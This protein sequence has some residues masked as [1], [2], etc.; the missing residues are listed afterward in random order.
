MI[1]SISILPCLSITRV[2]SKSTSDQ[3][4]CHFPGF[5]FLLLSKKSLL[6]PRF[7]S[8][9]RGYALC[10]PL[11]DFFPDSE[12][13]LC[14]KKLP[15]PRSFS[16]PACCLR[17]RTRCPRYGLHSMDTI[18][19]AS[20][21]PSLLLAR[22]YIISA[23]SPWLPLSFLILS[24]PQ[25]Q[26]LIILGNLPKILHDAISPTPPSLP[27][28]CSQG[29]IGQHPRYTIHFLFLPLQTLASTYLLMRQRRMFEKFITPLVAFPQNRSPRVLA[30]FSSPLVLVPTCIRLPAS[31]LPPRTLATFFPQRHLSS[32]AGDLPCERLPYTR[33]ITIRPRF[34]HDL[35]LRDNCHL[36]VPFRRMN[37]SQFSPLINSSPPF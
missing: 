10:F 7:F 36:S 4:S 19:S 20:Y 28:L 22:S 2:Q 24:F 32:G 9:Y 13:Y 15:S 25:H 12:A 5:T 6:I 8:S 30:A 34:V 3:S 18:L 31:S 35:V 21:S 27:S 14:S 16:F 29:I 33:V 23:V 17:E 1:R 11:L 26:P 37:V